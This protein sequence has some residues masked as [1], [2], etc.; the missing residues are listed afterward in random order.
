MKYGSMTR[1]YKIEEVDYS[2][3]QFVH[4]LMI[5]STMQPAQCMIEGCTENAEWQHNILTEKDRSILIC[6]KHHEEA[7]VKG[8]R[9]GA[10]MRYILN[11]AK[12]MMKR[13]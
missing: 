7:S 13:E 10:A 4:G 2:F 3:S 5:K 11:E 9:G 1:E 8:K 12:E 6:W